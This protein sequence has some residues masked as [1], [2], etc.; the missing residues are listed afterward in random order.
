MVQPSDTT[1]F[2]KC[3]DMK[4]NRSNKSRP[5]GFTRADLAALLAIF[6]LLLPLPLR[7]F[8]GN[9]GRT[10]RTAACMANQQRLTL[11]WN[12]YS[13]DNLGALP[14]ND[15]GAE[16]SPDLWVKGNV[17]FATSM[18]ENTDVTQITKGLLWPYVQNLSCY[19]CPA[20]PVRV[21]TRTTLEL[22]PMARSYSMNSWMKG[23][24]WTPGFH[25]F[26]NLNE[27]RKPQ[28]TFVF[29]DERYDSLNDSMFSVSMNG[30]PTN[31]AAAMIIDYPAFYHDNGAVIAFADE[32]VEHWIWSDP[33]T[34]PPPG[35]SALRLNIPSPNNQDIVR[36]Q[37]VS[38]YKD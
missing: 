11:A 16:L 24:L 6:A 33:R 32:H 18:P 7:I 1:A 8:G 30:Y 37:S 2:K 35:T 4:L 17:A 15:P 5:S 34:T 26:Q 12:L 23:R 38:T 20:D 29:V 3:L 25:V 28:N 9:F 36:L 21:R 22:K 10:S 19:V 14:D 27:I 31:A 13:A